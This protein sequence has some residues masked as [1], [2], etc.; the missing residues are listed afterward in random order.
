MMSSFGY[1]NFWQVRSTILYLIHFVMR[2]KVSEIK[3]LYVLV[4]FFLTVCM[5]DLKT[6]KA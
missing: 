4:K 2:S 1:L 3:Y 5:E 6:I